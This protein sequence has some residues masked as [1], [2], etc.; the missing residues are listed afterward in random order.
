MKYINYKINQFVDSKFY[1]KVVSFIIFSIAPVVLY[2]MWYFSSD[3]DQSSFKFI[4]NENLELIKKTVMKM[5]LIDWIPYVFIAFLIAYVLIPLMLFKDKIEDLVKDVLSKG[6]LFFIIIMML[7]FCDIKV[8]ELNKEI[9]TEINI[10]HQIDNIKIDKE[11][12]IDSLQIENLQLN[13]RWI[14]EKLKK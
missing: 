11:K 13:N 1:F 14:Q 5:N 12:L 9:I 8:N 7:L 3:N 6:L 2:L 4:I 10:N